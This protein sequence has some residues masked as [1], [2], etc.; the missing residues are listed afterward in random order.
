[1]FKTR[2]S[3]DLEANLLQY[4]RIEDKSESSQLKIKTGVRIYSNLMSFLV[5]DVTGTLSLEKENFLR[6]FFFFFYPDLME[7]PCQRHLCIVHYKSMLHTLV[8]PQ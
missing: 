1:M 2:N 4:I 3:K 6:F 5:H 7:F 8:S